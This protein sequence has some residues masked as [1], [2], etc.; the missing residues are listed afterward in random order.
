[1]ADA[2]TPALLFIPDISGFTQF[3]NDTEI[4]HSQFIIQELLE[5]LI[6]SDS[7]GMKVSEIEGDAILFYRPGDAPEPKALAEQAKRMF[8]AFHQRLKSYERDRICPCQACKSA[9]SLRLKFVVHQGAITVLKV[10]DREKLF[11]ADVIL[12]HRLLKNQVPENEYLLATE[13]LQLDRLADVAGYP[14]FTASKAS[15]TYDARAVSYHFASLQ[16]LHAQIPEPVPPEVKH[17]RSTRPMVFE[18]LVKAPPEKIFSLLTDLKARTRF[19]PGVREVRIENERHN[20]IIRVGT[21]HHCVL[22]NGTRDIVTSAAEVTA[23][24]LLLSE[25]D[26][27][28][29][30]TFDWIVE[31]ENGH[32]RVKIALHTAF[33]PIMQLVFALFVKRKLGRMIEETLDNLQRLSEAPG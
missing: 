29:P 31:R 27:K 24:R 2:A 21:V 3:V 23:D 11:G 22:D 19:M 1:M 20:H 33:N 9:A 10:K 13:A 26:L 18:R 4:T 17:Y 6:D 5:T 28:E 14:W 25:T 15:E 7:L 16:P 8:F 32:S 30:L 12:A